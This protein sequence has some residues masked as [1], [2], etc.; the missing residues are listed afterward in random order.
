MRTY[1]VE[2][3]RREYY[4]YSAMLRH[5]IRIRSIEKSFLVIFTFWKHTSAL[6]HNG[7]QRMQSRHLQSNNIHPT[8]ML[9]FQMLLFQMLLFQ[10]TVKRWVRLPMMD[11]YLGN[12]LKKNPI[13]SKPNSYFL[14][15]CWAHVPPTIVIV[16]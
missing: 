1:S 6:N 16:K 12:I 9:L 15:A 7:V 5:R 13:S 8:I 14:A 10:I 11:T 4:R 3:A 2:W